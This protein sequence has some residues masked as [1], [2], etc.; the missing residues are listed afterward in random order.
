MRAA[1]LAFAL[2]LLLA[3]PADALSLIDLGAGSSVSGVSADGSAAVGQGTDGEA[4]RWTT[5][6]GVQSLGVLPGNES[7]PGRASAAFAA[8]TD[9]SVVVG[10]DSTGADQA[11]VWTEAGGMQP[12]GFLPG[13]SDSFATDVS[14]DGSVVVGVSG[15]RAFRWTEAGG[16]E[17][18]VALG[19]NPETFFGESILLS[20]SGDGSTIAGA[21]NGEAFRWTDAGGIELLENPSPGFFDTYA[22]AISSDGSTV[23][24]T[25]YD[26]DYS[27]YAS[28]SWNATGEVSFIPRA[29]S[30]F[31]DQLSHLALAVS[32]DGSIVVGYEGISVLYESRLYP[33]AATIWTAAD[34]PRL[35]EDVL[36][37][38]G[39]D[40]GGWELSWA[41]GV[42]DTGGTIVGQGI[43]SGGST[44]GW[45]AVVPE[46][47]TGAL[48]GAGLAALAL[49]RRRVAGR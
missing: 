40:L 6:G 11:F 29:T 19:F 32:G 12:L 4:L 27:Q 39:F 33:G 35:L 18:I 30:T 45:I 23:V 3:P 37:E 31:G 46:P 21:T 24:G 2:A 41:T 26:S 7:A 9:G 44:R 49:A 20:V 8:S 15:G 13:A 34:G 10:V 47:A 36:P 14:G 22:N 1:A 42:S 43:G 16:M 28:E 17:E 48:L 25:S 5:S 38:L